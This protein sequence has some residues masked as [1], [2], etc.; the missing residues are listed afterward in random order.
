MEVISYYDSDDQKYWLEQ[1][2]KSDWQATA[3]LAQLISTDAFFRTLGENAKLLLLVDE[4]TLVSFCTYAEID[5]IQPTDLKPWMGFVYTFPA[6]R[7]HRYLELLFSEIERLAIIDK[8]SVVY[9]STDHVGL[10]EK[11][12]CE[13]LAEMKDIHGR[14]SRVY[15]KRINRI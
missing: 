15:V 12:G 11:Y 8:V 6:Y 4:D 13:Y 1:I 3:Y 14:M 7:G 5:D 2:R 9:I 10:Y